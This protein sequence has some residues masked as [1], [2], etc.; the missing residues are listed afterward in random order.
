MH[1]LSLP[2]A[3]DEVVV[4]RRDLGVCKTAE[5]PAGDLAHLT[6]LPLAGSFPRSHQVRERVEGIQTGDPEIGRFPTRITSQ[7]QAV[8]LGAGGACEVCAC[9]IGVARS[10]IDLCEL[11]RAF[12]FGRR[13]TKFSQREQYVRQGAESYS[14]CVPFSHG[15]SA[16]I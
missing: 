6:D 2:C 1:A 9:P 7:I 11:C 3:R 16:Q 10:G 5:T 4:Q 8:T 12:R 14:V 13:G 15:K